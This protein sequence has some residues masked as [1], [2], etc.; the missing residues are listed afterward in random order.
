MKDDSFGILGGVPIVRVSPDPDPAPKQPGTAR[1]II[2]SALGSAVFWVVS[3]VVGAAIVALLSYLGLRPTKEFG[4]G[5][6]Q[7]TEGLLIAVAGPMDCQPPPE[8]RFLPIAG[9]KSP[10]NLVSCVLPITVRNQADHNTS[11]RPDTYFVAGTQRHASEPTSGWL[12][13]IFP[14]SSA[15]TFVRTSFPVT[16]EEPNAV[17]I[18][19]KRWTLVQDG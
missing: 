16:S 13:D 3:V 7:E 6:T 19:G 8:Q 2:E 14:H 11:F 15:E 18:N 5:D 10:V 9:S 12:E 4:I 1:R 17:I